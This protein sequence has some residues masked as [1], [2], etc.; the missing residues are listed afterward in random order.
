MRFQAC[1]NTRKWVPTSQRLGQ[2]GSLAESELSLGFYFQHQT[3][4]FSYLR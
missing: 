3:K 1:G 2:S 4:I